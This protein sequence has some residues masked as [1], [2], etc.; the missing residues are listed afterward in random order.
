MPILLLILSLPL[1]SC[2]HVDV[3]SVHT[4]NSLAVDLVEV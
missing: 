3:G 2:P 1:D 4:M